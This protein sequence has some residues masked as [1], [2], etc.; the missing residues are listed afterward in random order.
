MSVL[1]MCGQIRAL[2]ACGAPQTDGCGSAW[3]GKIEFYKQGAISTSF[4]IDGALGR[5]SSLPDGATASLHR[6]EKQS[7]VRP[8]PQLYL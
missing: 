3:D 1:R 8:G 4:H 6:G 5:L 2:F 7:F